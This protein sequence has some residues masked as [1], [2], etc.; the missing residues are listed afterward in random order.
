MVEKESQMA[1]DHLCYHLDY[2]NLSGP[3]FPH[4]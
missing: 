2:L 3:Q 1:R 4:L